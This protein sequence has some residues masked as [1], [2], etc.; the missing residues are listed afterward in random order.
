[1]AKKTRKSSASQPTPKPAT[2]G[3]QPDLKS[4]IV[5]A[6]DRELG[7]GGTRVLEGGEFTRVGDG[8]TY[9]RPD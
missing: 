4:R 5:R 8:D 2:G 7:L 3:S 9:R 1:M 6:I